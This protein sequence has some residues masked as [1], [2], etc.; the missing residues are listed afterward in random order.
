MSISKP[1]SKA[2][3]ITR[4]SYPVPFV[5]RQQT[6]LL[7]F[8]RRHYADEPTSQSE[9]EASGATEAEHGENSIASSAD[10][11]ADANDANA[12]TPIEHAEE[13]HAEER[14]PESKVDS[15]ADSVKSATQ[16]VTDSVTGAAQGLSS[17]A[18]FGS[19]KSE[20]DTAPPSEDVST[21]VYVG[22]LFFDV[23]AEDL[24]KEF[25]KAGPVDSAKIIM[26]ARGL[27]KG[28]VFF[29]D[30]VY[31]FLRVPSKF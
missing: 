8:Q 1:A 11:G 12:S 26:D 9:P 15:A 22:N 20:A 21:T 3:C 14:T 16:S 10:S 7:A 5:K 30:P 25:A 24:E 4:L 23:K 17:A 31:D 18:G 29:L 27:S 6:S 13:E 28:F 19:Q 2:R